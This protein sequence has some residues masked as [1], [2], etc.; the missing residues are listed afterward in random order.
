MQQLID[1][2]DEFGRGVDQC[3]IEIKKYCIHGHAGFP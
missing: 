3:A 1:D 2:G